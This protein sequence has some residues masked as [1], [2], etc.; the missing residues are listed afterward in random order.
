MALRTFKVVYGSKPVELMI[1]CPLVLSFR[2]GLGLHENSDAWLSVGN[3]KI[4]YYLIILNIIT[5]EQIFDNSSNL[6]ATKK[7]IQY[8]VKVK[9]LSSYG[10]N[11]KIVT[12]S[13][14]VSLTD[15]GYLEKERTN[16]YL[17]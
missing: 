1:L 8:I 11:V 5:N 10:H 14:K 9:S 6:K 7:I 13:E 2:F 17:I 3:S 12:Y 16:F 15:S 4:N